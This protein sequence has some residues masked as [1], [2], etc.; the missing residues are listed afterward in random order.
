MKKLLT[1][2]ILAAGLSA[3]ATTNKMDLADNITSLEL[4]EHSEID[5][6]ATIEA[7]ETSFKNENY[8]GSLEL[9][10]R[11]V[12][13]EPGNIEAGL[14]Y[15]DAALA[16]GQSEVARQQFQNLRDLQLSD[17]NLEA[18]E[19]GLALSEILSG[20]LDDPVAYID[21]ATARHSA[22]PRLWNAKGLIHD[23]REEWLLA[24]DAYVNALKTGEAH[25]GIINNM[26]MSLIKQ[27]RFDEAQL[28]FEQALEIKP[29]SRLYDN[30][31]RLALFLDNKIRLGLKDI[32]DDRAASLLSDA[33]FIAMQQDRTA[34]AKMLMKHAIKTAPSYHVKAVENLKTLEA[35]ERETS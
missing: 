3:C 25:S 32:P 35:R 10:H 33:G 26:G 1:S 30:N 5:I 27:G 15:A 13:R 28:K 16:L 24:L 17:E 2:L 19:A 23:G 4:A 21:V 14:G 31:R 7:A 8:A 22:D 9:Y 6:E 11:V 29:E 12:L 34:L 18:V 20:D